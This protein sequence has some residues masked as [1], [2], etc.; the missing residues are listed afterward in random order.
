MRNITMSKCERRGFYPKVV[1]SWAHREDRDETL[2]CVTGIL[3][4]RLRYKK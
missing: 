2:K 4:S 1:G 3:V